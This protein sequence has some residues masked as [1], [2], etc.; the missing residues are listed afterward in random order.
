MVVGVLGKI[1]PHDIP[2]AGALGGREG[3][4]ATEGRIGRYNSSPCWRMAN[5]R[6]RYSHS[7]PVGCSLPTRP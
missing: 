7:S 1:C 4:A 2:P 3:A 6:S 5:V